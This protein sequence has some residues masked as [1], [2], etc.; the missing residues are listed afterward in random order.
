M[1]SFENVNGTIMVSGGITHTLCPSPH[2]VRTPHVT[3]LDQGSAPAFQWQNEFTAFKSRQN[4]HLSL[5]K[6]VTETLCYFYFEY[7]FS[8]I[9]FFR[10]LC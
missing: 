7:I 9:H 2:M 1:V 10:T 3:P 8:V 4:K 5:L 6:P